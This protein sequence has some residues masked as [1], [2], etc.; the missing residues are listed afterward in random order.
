MY[1]RSAPPRRRDPVR[2]RH[3]TEAAL[4]EVAGHRVAPDRMV[5]DDHHRRGSVSSHSVPPP[6]EVFSLA[7]PPSHFIRPTI[8]LATPTRPSATA[9]ASLPSA[10]PTPSSR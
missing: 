9:S 4:G 8:D 1:H 3:H 2:R 6:G 10:I 5:V 7:L